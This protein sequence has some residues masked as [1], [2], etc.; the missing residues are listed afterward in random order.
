[1]EKDDK[2]IKELNE[3]FYKLTIIHLMTMKTL[4]TPTYVLEAGT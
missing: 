1:V 3:I 2:P 4:D